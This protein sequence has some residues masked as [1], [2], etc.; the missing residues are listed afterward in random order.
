MIGVIRNTSVRFSE[1]IE[2]FFK[3]RIE[4]LQDNYDFGPEKRINVTG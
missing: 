4:V 2:D 3:S 1:V